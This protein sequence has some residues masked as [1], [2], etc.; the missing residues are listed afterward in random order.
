MRIP[1]FASVL[2][3]AAVLCLA[4]CRAACLGAETPAAEF[5]SDSLFDRI[6]SVVQGWGELGVNTAVRPLHQTPMKLRVKDKNYEHG[7]GHHANGEII[8]DLGGQFKT[9]QTDIG[10]QWQ[11]GQNTASAIFQIFV[12]DK[13][14]FDS[15]IVRENDPPRQVS[16]S[17]EG[18]EELRLVAGDAG[19]GITCDCTNWA[20]ARLVRNPAA[21]KKPMATGVDMAPFGKVA[22]W[23]PKQMG[24]TKAG[25]V[26]EIPAE[27]LFP[28]KDLLPSADGTYKVPDWSGT[29]CIGLRWDENRLLRQLVLRFPDAASV[30]ATGSVQL[31]FWTGESAWQGAWQPAR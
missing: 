1:P 10:I 16:V 30:P 19:D 24:G 29:G 13:K 7:L 27:D 21:A 15:G 4:S 12:D 28:A 6:V 11:G 9:F 14:V 22:T 2:L 18:A 31:Q 20:D 8:V 25:R 3:A 26:D 17:V 23:D 5:L